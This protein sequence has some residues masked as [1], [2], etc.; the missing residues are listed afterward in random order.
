MLR[1]VAWRL[2]A[3]VPIL[4]GVSIVTFLLMRLVPGDFTL[5]L[6]GPFATD[7]SVAALREYYGLN[8]PLYVQ[9]LKWLAAL[10]HGDF[11]KSVAFQVPVAQVLGDR[12]VNTL[13]LTAAS[14]TLSIGLG[15]LGGSIAGVRKFSLFDRCSTLA[16]LVISSAP[17]FW[18]GLVMLY[19]FALRLHW[20]PAVGMHTIGLEG[21]LWDLLWHVPLPAFSAS[22]VSLAVIFRLTRAGVLDT[23]AQD[24]IRAARARGVPER[25]LIFRHA[26]RSILP[27]IV[28]ISGLQVGF[29]FG[30]AVFAEVIFQW[31]GVGLLMYNAIV[32]R[33]VP[34]IQAVLL[35][36]AVVFVIANLISDL[37]TAALNPQARR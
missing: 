17:T 36:I 3:I 21:N 28:N 33:D 16:A 10:A 22:V 26:I 19:I 34:V 25:T 6:L 23:M 30:S 31:P 29:I 7:E 32:S 9:Y 18:F 13:I 5:A 14:A 4:L 12:V 15:F 27:A 24:H 35:V 37:I 1:F 8:Q 2:M 11:G 20:F